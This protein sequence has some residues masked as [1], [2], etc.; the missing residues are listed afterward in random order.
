MDT[1][2]PFP[3]STCDNPCMTALVEANT[4]VC[5]SLI[6]ALTHAWFCLIH[7]LSWWE[8]FV[9]SR[10]LSTTPLRGSLQRLY[11]QALLWT[12]LAV[13][14]LSSFRRSHG[15]PSSNRTP[16]EVEEL[17]CNLKVDHPHLG[18]GQLRLLLHRLSG[19]LLGRETIRLILLRC[20]SR[21]RDFTASKK[22]PPATIRVHGPRSL[23]GIDT[24]L[25]W[26]LGLYP[27]WLVGIV[28]YH[29]SRVIALE[30]LRFHTAAEIV[31]VLDKAI[32]EHGPPDRIL[33]DNGRQFRSLDFELFLCQHD[34]LHT[35]TRPG[36]PWTNGRIERIW[37]TFKE[38]IFIGRWLIFSVKQLDRYCTDFVTFYNRDRPHSSWGGRT[39]DEVYFGRNKH[40]GHL[41]RVTYFDGVLNW[42][43]FG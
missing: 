21:V 2:G 32:A 12:G 34:I 29:G 31:R 23:W 17:I 5:R 10:S 25:V 18:A 33:S 13:P 26:I 27:I 37:R 43:R 14:I 4:W 6:S 42:Y 20:A 36:H 22:R 16:P 41:G 7:A 40:I 24:S 11:Q 28:D 15:R 39:P 30:T 3:V 1:T 35:F 38:T 19:T 8:T 9:R